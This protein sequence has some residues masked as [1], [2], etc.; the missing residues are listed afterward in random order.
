[1]RSTVFAAI[2]MTVGSISLAGSQRVAL[3]VQVPAETPADAKVFVAGSVP[4]LGN[5]RPDG[6]SLPRQPNGTYT[7]E[8]ELAAGQSIEFKITRGTWATVEQNADG[9]D[10]PN[11]TATIDAD[12][13]KIEV[14]VARWATGKPASR[15]PNTVVGTLKLHTIESRHLKLA[16]TIRVWLPLGYDANPSARYDVLYMHDGQNCFDRATSAFGNEWEIDESLTKLIAAKEISPLIV[17][18]IDNGLANRINELTYTA[19]AK[20]GGG[21]A[22]AYAAF[23]LEE[24]KP[25]VERTYCPNTGPT[26]TFLGGSSLGGLVSLEIAR[27]HPNT[28]GGVIAM[29]PALQWADESLTHDIE[30]DPSG[31]RTTRIWLDVGTQEMGTPPIITKSPAEPANSN[32]TVNSTASNPVSDDP[33][34]RLLTA[35]K[36]LDAALTKHN[37]SRRFIIDADHPAHNES[38]WAARFPEAIHYL[39]NG[40]QPSNKRN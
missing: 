20:R 1:M 8:V 16:R 23:L 18:G 3:V 26:H 28:F 12:T 35:A 15:P 36:R 34:A 38:A 9:S 17:V 6:L 40:D 11:R 25:F 29:S 32:S 14:T 30:R 10:R 39:V 2:L 5:W 22:A 21:Q 31:L 27:R 19:D 4:V 33:S 13:Q 24:M 37:I 7:A